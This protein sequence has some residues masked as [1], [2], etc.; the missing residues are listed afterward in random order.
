MGQ[1]NTLG[2]FIIILTTWFSL[3]VEIVEKVGGEISGE[4]CCGVKNTGKVE[5]ILSILCTKNSIQIYRPEADAHADSSELSAF[6]V[7]Y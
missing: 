5:W 3:T 7:I 1:V 2:E 4:M 6:I